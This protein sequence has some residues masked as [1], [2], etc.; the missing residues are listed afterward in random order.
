M[1]WRKWDNVPFLSINS[2]RKE[3]ICNWADY[4]VPIT[5]RD[6]DIGAGE[7]SPSEKYISLIVAAVNNDGIKVKG[8]F[9][10]SLMD[11]FEWGNGYK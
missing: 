1:L 5:N 6:F 3:K 4:R 8:Y 2:T 11:N 7:F 10:W 9:A